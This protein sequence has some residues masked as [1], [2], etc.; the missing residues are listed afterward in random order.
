MT[1]KCSLSI[2]V[3]L[4]NKEHY[5]EKCLR[6]LLT[7]DIPDEDYEVIVIN[8]G[9]LDQSREIV[10]RLK[11]EFRNLILIDQANEGV[12]AARNAGILSAKGKFLLFIDADDY[13][14]TNSLGQLIEYA[15]REYLDVMYLSFAVYNN[16]GIF[17]GETDY[18]LLKGKIFDGLKTYL[19][20]HGKKERDSDRSVGIIIRKSILQ[21]N[22]LSYLN[23]MPYLEDGHFIGKIL[24]LA[25]RCAFSD[26]PF[27]IHLI[28]PESASNS[29]LYITSRAR[30]GFIKAALDFQ[31]FTKITSHTITRQSL[32]NHL[33]AKFVLTSV[34]SSI[35]TKKII[36]VLQVK[37]HLK[38]VGLNKINSNGLVSNKAYLRIYNHSFWLFVC[39]YLLETRIRTILNTFLGRQNDDINY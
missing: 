18:S 5:I 27:Y 23:D 9:S 6:S 16:N 38:M 29:D 37:R 1:N 32:V 10:L 34:I 7:Q 2:I 25:E 3:P 17:C 13:V 20:T 36:E 35:N 8:D 31:D 28:N 12:S 33:T 4:Y 21:K 22:K 14:A 11:K 39:Y 19:I 26:D 30:K 15:E 24:C